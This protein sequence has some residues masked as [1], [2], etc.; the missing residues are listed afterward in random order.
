M[1]DK[2]NIFAVKNKIINCIFIFSILILIS[3][4]S[5]NPSTG[6]NEFT[7]MSKEEEDKIGKKEHPKII[8]SLGGIYKNEQLQ[9][10]VESL[11]EFL[12]NTSE[13]PNKKFTFTILDTPVVNAFAL[14]HNVIRRHTTQKHRCRFA[15]Y[16][17]CI[18]SSNH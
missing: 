13:L 6:K 12:V 9:N 3:N 11:G 4:C 14:P 17:R 5:V 8:K 18:D 7:I 1:D 16:T 15:I 2:N 10:Y